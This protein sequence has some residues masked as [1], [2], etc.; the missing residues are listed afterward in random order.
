MTLTRRL[1]MQFSVRS[2]APFVRDRS[3]IGHCR[4]V[5]TVPPLPHKLLLLL[6][7]PLLMSQT[8]CC[9]DNH[10]IDSDYRQMYCD[11]DAVFRGS[12]VM[13]ASSV[14][15]DAEGLQNEASTHTF[16]VQQWYRYTPGVSPDPPDRVTVGRTWRQDDPCDSASFP[17]P[18]R[19]GDF[20]VFASSAGSYRYTVQT[21][22]HSFPWACLPDSFKNS[23]PVVC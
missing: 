2:L 17:D 19:S 13:A 14:A 23:L 11:A 7:L 3:M 9:E 8:L 18:T 22:R 20:L 12:P 16:Q 6:M 4:M 21:C 15:L 1:G 10:L 5:L